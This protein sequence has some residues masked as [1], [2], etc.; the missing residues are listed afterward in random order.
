MQRDFRF[1]AAQAPKSSEL[2]AFANL[3]IFSDFISS[4]LANEQ[5]LMAQEFRVAYSEQLLS[6]N[7]RHVA[8]GML[9]EPRL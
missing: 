1:H 5:A 2:P 4:K 8:M 7:E 3:D 9:A 6:A